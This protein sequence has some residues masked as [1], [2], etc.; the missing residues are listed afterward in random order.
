MKEGRLEMDATGNGRVKVAVESIVV[1]DIENSAGESNTAGRREAATL[2]VRENLV[3][4]EIFV[5]PPAAA[6]IP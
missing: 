3:L 2:V 6:D 1:E 5:V 4:V